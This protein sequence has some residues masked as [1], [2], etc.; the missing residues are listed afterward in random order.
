MSLRKNLISGMKTLAIVTGIAMYAGAA[1]SQSTNT[2]P[3][4][5]VSM[6]V[7]SVLTSPSGSVEKGGPITASAMAG[8]GSAFIVSGVAQGSGEVISVIL[9]A[10]GNA[11]K[12]SVQISKS[13]FEKLGVSVGATVNAVTQSTGVVLVASGKVLAFIPN[14]VGEALLHRE[15]MPDAPA[16]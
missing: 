2:T 6:G 10:V 1:Y 5:Q 12:L 11:G 13:A 15:R 4:E 8:M 7:V 9:N 16:K 3:S 14:T